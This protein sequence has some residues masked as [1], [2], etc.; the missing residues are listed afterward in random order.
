MAEP[1]GAERLEGAAHRGGAGDLACVGHRAQ[2]ER[3]GELER[4]LV[5]LGRELGFKPAEAHGDDSPLAVLRR[6]A[7]D[8]FGLLSG[9]AAENVRCQ[10][11]LDAVSF[12]RLLCPVAVAA[13]DLVPGDASRHALRGAEDRLEV[14]GF[15]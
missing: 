12:P 13:E 3:V 6:V 5:R 14:D 4:W 10:T 8:L 2:A 7:D 9:R 11:H 15:M 1:V